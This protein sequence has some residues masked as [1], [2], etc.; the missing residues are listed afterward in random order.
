VELESLE[1]IPFA[2]APGA[3]AGH[4]A[5][6]GTDTAALPVLELD[7][8]DNQDSSPTPTIDQ[9]LRRRKK[10]K[11]PSKSGK[12]RFWEGSLEFQRNFLMPLVLGLCLWLVLTVVTCFSYETNL[13][14]IFFGY[15]IFGIGRW[16][17]V[18]AALDEGVFHWAGCLLIPFYPTYYFLTRPDRA[19]GPFF[20]GCVGVLFLMTG[21]TFRIVR[22]WEDFMPAGTA[23]DDEDGEVSGGMTHDAQCRELLEEPGRTAEAREWLKLPNHHFNRWTHEQ[24][25]DNVAELYAL[26][27]KSVT[28]VSIEKVRDAQ[29][30]EQCWQ[31]VVKL[32]SDRGRRKLILKCQTKWFPSTASESDRGQTYM[33]LTV[34]DVHP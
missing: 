11:R 21:Y 23:V 24:A 12:P 22:H 30:S 6:G 2:P 20:V 9:P 1:L 15:A 34:P 19:A 18:F 29:A 28:A 7:P 32:P 3:T 17:L 4:E 14:L 16:M 8:D 5:L 13:F 10:R 25:I 27:A 26:G 31:L 33:L